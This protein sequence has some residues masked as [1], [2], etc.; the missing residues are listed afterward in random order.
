MNCVYKYAWLIISG[1]IQSELISGCFGGGSG[2]MLGPGG[3]YTP[4]A[5]GGTGIMSSVHQVFL[6][7]R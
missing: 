4:G 7:S 3:C 5:M 1:G 2:G 6:H